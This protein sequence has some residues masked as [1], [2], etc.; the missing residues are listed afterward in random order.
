[1]EIKMALF[2]IVLGLGR[3]ECCENR[4]IHVG[5]YRSQGF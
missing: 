4:Q 5:S 1:M 2:G 3:P